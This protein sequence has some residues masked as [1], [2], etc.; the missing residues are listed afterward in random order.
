M[1]AIILAAGYA[2]RLYPLTKEKPK[3]LLE[4]KGKP[5]LEH[6]LDELHFIKEINEVFVITNDR[7]FKNF[8]DWKLNYSGKLKVTIVNDGTKTNEDRLG[9]LGDIKF[10][11]ENMCINEDVVIVAGDNLFEFSLQ[12]LFQHY[13]NKKKPVVVLYDVLDIEL[14]KQYG[15]VSID[16]SGKIINFEEKPTIPKSTLSSTGI[17]V[18]PMKTI[19]K[20]IEFVNLHGKKDKA[21]DF[22]E[23]L[24]TQEEVYTHLTNDKWFDIGT[25]DQLEKARR[26]YNIPHHRKKIK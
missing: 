13:S 17:Y 24:H 12:E 11:I 10:V 20:L 2:T 15:I 19:N 21:G 14:A 8:L 16:D 18:Y 9:S 7:F 3:P 26:D 22:L 1:K 5:I 4:V 23:W 25:L 6:I